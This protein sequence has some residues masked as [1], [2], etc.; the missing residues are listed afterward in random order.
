MGKINLDDAA[1]EVFSHAL[2]RTPA[3][4]LVVLA[5]DP[6][7]ASTGWA[8]TDG[9]RWLFDQKPV[10]KA[11]QLIVDDSGGVDL[12]VIEAPYSGATGTTERSNPLALYQ[13][14][15]AAGMIEGA[16]RSWGVTCPIWRPQPSTW[17]S[18]LGLNRRSSAPGA[19]DARE[20]TADAVH[21]WAS[22]TVRDPLL[23]NGGGKQ[24]DTAMAIGMV[25][26][27]RGVARWHAKQR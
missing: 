5:I 17:R 16:L 8:K 6:G 19:R 23:G 4:A 25:A 27:A 20:I 24:I 26:A 10:G 22:T 11:L 1:L 3:H 21:L 13:L 18:A 14:G 12:L 7:T 9:H 2:E 15:R